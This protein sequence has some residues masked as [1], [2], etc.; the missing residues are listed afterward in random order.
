MRHSIMICIFF[1]GLGTAQAT[2]LTGFT[3]EFSPFN[4]TENGQ[5]KGL[6]N[7][8][9]DRISSKTG[10]R[11][12][13]KVYPWLRAVEANQAVDNSLLFTT[14]R[15]PERETKF[16]WVGP[17]DECEIWLI[18]LKSRKDVVASNIEQAKQYQVG[19]PR[20]SAGNSLLLSKGFKENKLDLSLDEERNIRKLYAGRFDF[21]V[22]LIVPHYASAKKL[23]L[24]VEDLDPVI[25][26]EK[27]L[28]CYFAFNPKVD[29]A[30][31]RRFSDAFNELDKS[32]ELE[33]I[34]NAF[35]N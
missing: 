3:E 33:K 21:S 15:T 14:V 8:I 20:G 1:M 34:R 17:Y 9:I 2:D 7:E 30:L 18:K 31:F 13:R 11:V 22:G 6:A 24:P 32:G 26:L 35:L 4:Y 28:G 12:A 10:L 5:H 25:R 16:L 29:P 19:A 27:G 23:K